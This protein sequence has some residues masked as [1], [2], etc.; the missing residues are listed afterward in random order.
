[1]KN[2]QKT[3]KCPKGTV[4][5]PGQLNILEKYSTENVLQNGLS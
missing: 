5:L 1:M 3:L 2:T 4:I